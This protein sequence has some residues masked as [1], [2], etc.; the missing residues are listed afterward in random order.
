MPGCARVHAMANT[1]L[2]PAACAHN[3]GSCQLSC[4]WLQRQG[5]L[6]AKQKL[7][8][9]R[10]AMLAGIG[11]TLRLSRRV[12]V[13]HAA[14]RGLNAHERRLA[15]R[16]WRDADRRAAAVRRAEAQQV[17]ADTHAAGRAAKQLAAR[18]RQLAEAAGNVASNAPGARTPGAGAALSAGSSLA[19]RLRRSRTG[20]AHVGGSPAG[21]SGA[22]AQAAPAAAT[23]GPSQRG[24]VTASNSSSAAS[25]AAIPRE[26]PTQPQAEAGGDHAQRVAHEPLMF[27]P[28]SRSRRQPRGASRQEAWQRRQAG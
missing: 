22:D 21:S 12:V 18:R 24:P 9:Q 3:P 7:P 11:V 2:R 19:G 15:R 27:S 6:L 17:A 25:G 8:S 1:L 26:P 4:R 16:R 23:H 20:R 28:N 5:R 10:R 13:R 14:L